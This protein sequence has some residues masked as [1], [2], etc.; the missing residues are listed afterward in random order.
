M[1]CRQFSFT[2]EHKRTFAKRKRT[3][4]FFV[5]NTKD[6][7][8][9]LVR[10]LDQKYL[11]L[12]TRNKI[13]QKKGWNMPW[14]REWLNIDGLKKK[15]GEYGLLGGKKIGDKYLSFLDLDIRKE[16]FEEWRIKQLEKNVGLL[17]DYLGCFHVKTKK[18]FHVYIL[19]DELLPNQ[20]IYHI[21]SWLEKEKIIGSIQSKGKYVVANL[22]KHYELDCWKEHHELKKIIKQIQPIEI[23][24]SADI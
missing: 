22:Q 6:K 13:P 15:Y 17:L 19:S 1:C 5:D 4:F 20:I 24:K 2:H 9:E 10:R 11:R 7:K 21:D 16:G 3:F 8:Q 23:T 18:G 14:F 12:P